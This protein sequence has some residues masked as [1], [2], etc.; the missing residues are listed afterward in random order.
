MKVIVD[1]W[2]GDRSQ[3]HLARYIDDIAMAL[4]RAQSE[5]Q[6]GFLVNLRCD[7]AWGEYKS[8]DNRRE[9]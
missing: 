9:Q 4:L 6:K 3:E 7:H 2:G 8:F 5:L 1:I